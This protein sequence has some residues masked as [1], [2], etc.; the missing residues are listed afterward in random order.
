IVTSRGAVKHIRGMARLLTQIEGRPLFIGALQDVT[1]SKIAEDAIRASERNL[2]LI[3][4]TIPALAWSARADGSAE[5]FNQHYLDYVGLSAEQARDWGWT[6]AVHVDDLN[7]FAATWQRIMV[8]G[9]RGEAEARLRRHDGN[10][11]WFLV[12]VS[13]LRDEKGNIVKWYGINTD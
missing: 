3:I 10:Y 8:S 11:R 2:K 12:R 1:E 13:P 4:D 5:F 9:E 7:G 6:A